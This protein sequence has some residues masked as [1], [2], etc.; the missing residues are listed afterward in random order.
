VVWA[1]NCLGAQLTQAE[2]QKPADC[3]R[4]AGF[5]LLYFSVRM[6]KIPCYDKR[7]DGW[8]ASSRTILGGNMNFFNIAKFNSCGLAGLRACGLAGLRA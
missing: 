5:L 8:L 4:S 1:C 2:N 3:A 7:H 6:Q